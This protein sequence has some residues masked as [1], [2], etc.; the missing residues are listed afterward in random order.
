MIDTTKL[1]EL[2]M[3]ATPGLIDRDEEMMRDYIP[4]PGDWEIQTKGKGSTFRIARTD[5][6]RKRFAVGDESLYGPL[7]QMARDIHAAANPATV[8][9][10]LDE[11]ERTQGSVAIASAALSAAEREVQRLRKIEAAA[12]NLAKVKGRH[13][14]E[15]AYQQLERVLK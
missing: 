15:Q 9:Q 4:L 6:S 11:L 8:L 7:E 3:K 2:A 10:L 13:H 5:G 14:S 12:R 1:R